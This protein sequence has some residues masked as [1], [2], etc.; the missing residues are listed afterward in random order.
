MFLR[1]WLNYWKNQ[2]RSG[3][4]GRRGARRPG[5]GTFRPGLEPLECRWLP[6]VNVTA[7]FKGLDELD[8]GG[9]V[10]PPDTIAAA[11]PNHI[12]EIVNSNIAAYDKTTHTRVLNEDLGTFFTVDTVQSLFSDVY[13]LYDEDI[14]RWFVSTMDIDF[15]NLQSYFDFAV[16]N[17]SDPTHGWTE[18]H[19]VNTTEVSERTGETLFTDFPRVGRNADAIVVS[20]NMY[21]FQTENPYSVQ[22]LTIQLNTVTDQNPNTLTTFTV[23]RPLP[24]STMVPAMMHGASPGGPMWFV[25]EKGLED[26]GD[27]ENLKVVKMTNVLSSTPTFATTFIPVAPYTITPFPND[28]N[29]QVTTAID[30]RIQSADWRNNLLVASHNVG[31]ASDTDVHARWYEFS[32]SGTSPSLLQQGTVVQGAGIGTYMPSVALAPDGSIGMTFIESSDTEEMSMYVTGRTPGDPAGTMETPALAK[33]GEANYAG[34]RAGDF[35]GITVDPSTGNTFWAANE[36][37]FPGNGGLTEPNWSTWIADFSL[38]D[39][40]GP[41]TWTGNGTNTNWSNGANWSG[42]V[43]PQAGDSIVFGPGASQLTST[44]DLP[45][46]TQ[47]ASI[48]LT[49]GGYSI[50]GNAVSL[51]GGLDD[52]GATGNNTVALPIT[53]TQD[54]TFQAPSGSTSLTLSGTI[55]NGGFVLTFG[56]GNG[57]LTSSGVISGAG[58]LVV[59]TPGT[60]TLSGAGNTYTGTTT[61]QSGTLVLAKSSGNAV[62]A[63]LV[64]SAGSI[65][66]RLTAG[67]QIAAAAA[68]TV[69]SGALLDLNNNSDTFGALTLNAGSLSTGT[70]TATLNGDVTSTG[71]SSVSGKLA[72]GAATRTFSVTAAADTLTVSAAVSG[73]VGLTKSGAGTLILSG[74]NTYSG[75]TTLGNGTLAVGGNSALGTG[76]VSLQAG[77]LRANGAAV[78]LA[79][80]V[81]LDGNVTLG[82]TLALTFT[83]AAT[84]TGNRTLTVSN[85]AATTFTAAVGQSGGAWSLTEAGS[86]QLVLSGASTYTGG[87]FLS[88]GTLTVGNNTALGTGSL[89]LN[90]GTLTATGGAISLANPVTLGGTVTIAGTQNLT[91]TGTT[92]LTGNRT[93][94]VSGSGL[95]RFSGP[96]TESGGAHSLTKIGGGVLVFSAANSYTGGTTLNGGTLGLGNAGALGTGALTLTSGILRADTVPV[97]IANAVTFIGAVTIGGSLNLTFTGAATLTINITLAVTNTGVTTF[98]GPVGESGGAHKLTKSGN[99]QLVLSAANTYSGGTV[100]SAGTLTAGNNGALGTGTLTPSA[101][102]ITATGGPISLANAVSLAGSITFG[103]SAN[104]TLTGAVTLTGSFTLTVN[105]TGVTTLAGAI[106]EAGGSRTLTKMGSGVLVLSGTNT[107]TGTT[108]VMS[109]S[110]LVN[111]SQAGNVVAVKNTATLGGSGTVGPVNMQLG[112]TLMPGTSSAQ[113]GILNC[114]NLTFVAGSNFNVALNGTT[115]GSGY[116]QANVTGTVN[117][118][119]STLHLTLG[120]TPAVGAAFTIINND[121]TDAVVGTFAGL[122]QNSTFVVNGMTFQINY[123]GGTGNDVVVTRIAAPV[124]APKLETQS[125][126]WLWTWIPGLLLRPGQRPGF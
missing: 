40:P 100:L 99:G 74:A 111:G 50:S 84:L 38:S 80:A 125:T 109:G 103:G 95:T 44:N 86:G 65:T 24:N 112:G 101:G 106:G 91:F 61:V 82:G 20:F 60:T 21:G 10:E 54:E 67:N 27:Y 108:T 42:G 12:V 117:L 47:F 78:S 15:V 2:T 16:S 6:T 26:S 110:L 33:A 98:A 89:A 123:Q 23:D 45:A 29:G 8:A 85:T 96:I 37:A 48:T 49:G 97:S 19:I 87:T 52:S 17:D 90:A 63:T 25:E 30:T 83:G 119:G 13:V 115:V 32:T 57:Q 76:T 126:T 104:L 22:I 102:T 70:G 36:Y 113:T 66:V 43:A 71:A 94:A 81:S 34:T 120:F 59:N 121:G 75:P 105:N 72:L 107:Y 79:N 118:A 122:T 18:Q 9:I 56:G 53:L 116:D 92:T 5:R 114:G 58:S 28:P 35:S 93:L 124:S 68:V 31:I 39:S 7:G 73:G 55:A 46:G 51:T 14:G 88:A 3:S 1:N 77:T 69:N 41:P 62:P 64:L 4:N 11:G